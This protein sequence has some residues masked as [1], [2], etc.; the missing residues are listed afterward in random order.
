MLSLLMALLEMQLDI[1]EEKFQ[2]L[3]IR[4]L[5]VFLRL[6]TLYKNL[7]KTNISITIKIVWTDKAS[8]LPMAPKKL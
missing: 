5:K 2:I 4:P 7:F 1:L 8:V 3:I 6:L